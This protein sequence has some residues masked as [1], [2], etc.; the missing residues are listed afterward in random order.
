MMA[1]ILYDNAT[2]PRFM[3]TGYPTA[4]VS[5][6]VIRSLSG[7]KA[8]IRWTDPEDTVL[9]NVVL[10]AWQGTIVVR[11][12]GAVPEDIED[13]VVVVENTTRNQ[14]QTNEYVDSSGLIGGHTYY[15]RFFTVSTEGVVG[16]G[17]PTVKMTAKAI[18]SVL[19]ENDWPTII[20]VA[21]SGAAAQTW[22]IGDEI[23]IIDVDG[24]TMTFQIFDFAHYDKADG[25]GK[26]AITFGSKHLYYATYSDGKGAGANY[27]NILPQEIKSAVK[28]VSYKYDDVIG[29]KS[30]IL[31]TTIPNITEVGLYDSQDQSEGYVFPIFTSNESRIKR[32][33]NGQGDASNW[34]TKTKRYAPTTGSHWT[35]GVSS[36]GGNISIRSGS[37]GVCLIFSI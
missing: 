8:G 37:A 19:S 4:D 29:M 9:D 1:N 32:M 17:S 10:A 11:K 25:S 7:L 28:Q 31:Y 35:S 20:E 15:Y 2:S 26:T 13:G 5:N 33:N 34:W 3:G 6:I 30:E 12:E 23:D 22:S 24:Y 14:Y 16:D 36:T 18:S 21:E 27:Y